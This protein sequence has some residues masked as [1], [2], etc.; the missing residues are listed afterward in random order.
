M[1][2]V[3]NDA[4]VRILNKTSHIFI[5]SSQI[6]VWIRKGMNRISIYSV[7]KFTGLNSLEFKINYRKKSPTIQT[8]RTTALTSS[9]TLPVRNPEV[10]VAT[11]C[12][13]PNARQGQCSAPDAYPSSSR[14][15][16]FISTSQMRKLRLSEMKCLVQ[17]T[18]LLSAKD[19]TSIQIWYSK[20]TL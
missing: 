5:I 3:I 16:V 19:G 1:V 15:P 2:N 9:S 7:S 20:R 10:T 18:H 11:I 13:E 6:H 12:W 17:V 14:E 4:G 8:I